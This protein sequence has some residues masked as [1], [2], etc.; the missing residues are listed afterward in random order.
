MNIKAITTN[1]QPEE[2]P[3]HN[4]KLLTHPERKY[5]T[6]PTKNG[7]DVQRV[8]KI[9]NKIAEVRSPVFP[10]EIYKAIGKTI[11][12]KT[13]KNGRTPPKTK[14]TL[15][16]K[17]TIKNKRFFPQ[18]QILATI[19]KLKRKKKKLEESTLKKRLFQGKKNKRRGVTNT[20]TPPPPATNLAQTITYQPHPVTP[21]SLVLTSHTPR[22]DFFQAKERKKKKFKTNPTPTQL[23]SIT[24]G[25]G[26]GNPTSGWQPEII[27]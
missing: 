26:T 12:S 17:R 8:Y 20:P 21:A 16:L 11:T 15:E 1:N 6:S 25:K 14:Q 23:K 2:W 10:I 24:W 7:I 5:H 27:I 18:T 3:P 9:K 19:T 4:S 13:T 22:T